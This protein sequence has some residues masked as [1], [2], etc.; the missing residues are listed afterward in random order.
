M[1]QSGGL[2]PENDVCH[3]PGRD[4]SL[5]RMNASHGVPVKAS[6]KADVRSLQSQLHKVNGQSASG[7][8]VILPWSS[9][10]EVLGI[11]TVQ[12]GFV[13]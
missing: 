8:R 9:I 7:D 5:R 12:L 13:V 10:S 1:G 6:K 3:L 4:T 2:N 11:K